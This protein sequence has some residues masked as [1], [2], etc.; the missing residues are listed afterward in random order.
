ML[1]APLFSPCHCRPP[2]CPPF[3]VLPS[4]QNPRGKPWTDMAQHMRLEAY[5]LADSR[6]CAKLVM[7]R[8]GGGGA[9]E[10]MHIL[11]ECVAVVHHK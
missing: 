1:L 4:S 2:K 5:S 7:I 3:F 9:K 6:K 11:V 10:A 8:Q